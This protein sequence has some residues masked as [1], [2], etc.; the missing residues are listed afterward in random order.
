[1]V[2]VALVNNITLLV[3]LS[4]VHGIIMRRWRQESPAY[5]LIS[6][7]LFGGVTIIGMMIPLRLMP[8]VI[9]D[10]RSIIISVAGLF[11]GP[12]TALTTAALAA[13][14]R[15]WLGGTGALMGVCVIS[16]SALVG[17]L[18]YFLRRRD[19]RIMRPFWL[20]LFG[21]V[22]HVIM[23]ALTRTLPSAVSTQVFHQIAFP[24]IVVYPMASLLVCMLFLDQESRIR[25]ERALRAS[26][27][28]YRELVENVHSIILRWKPDGTISFMNSFGLQ[29]F[30]WSIDELVGRHVVGTIVPETEDTG[31]DLTR[32]MEDIISHPERHADNENE[33]MRRDGSR[34]W[35]RWLN[36]P[37]KDKHGNL[38]ELFSTGYDITDRKKAEAERNALE[39]RLRQS[40][41]LEAV[42]LL[43]GG[44]A[45]DFNNLLSP[46]LG[47]GEM[48][49]SDETLSD[50]QRTDIAE[51]VKAGKRARDLVKQLMAFGRKQTLEIKPLDLNGVVTG[52]AKLLRRTLREDIRLELSLASN[53]GSIRADQGQL[54]QVI[55]NLGVNAQDAMPNGGTLRIETSNVEV[56]NGQAPPPDTGTGQYVLLSLSDTGV[57]MDPET[58]ERIFEPFFTTK[59]PG[60]G[61]GLG[62]ASVY[63]IVKQH[64]GHI[65]VDSALGRGTTFRI[66]LPLADPPEQQE[67]DGPQEESFRGTETVLVAEDDPSVRELVCTMLRRM[68]YCVI[69][70]ATAIECMREVERF[71]GEI[72]LLLSDVVMPDMSGC[73]LAERLQKSRANMKVLYMS[74]YATNVIAQRGALDEGT[75]IIHKPFSQNDLGRRLLRMLDAS[76]G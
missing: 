70:A 57:G 2:F 48:L 49:E 58:Q 47:F 59:A 73:E 52:F 76:R 40:H 38:V 22:V 56:K 29:L 6:G 20:Y 33:N 74:G 10:G 36:H 4:L 25:A 16:E 1:M 45:H 24:V 5:K 11:G 61:V 28:S 26:K 46:I 12:I 23:L 35:I 62:L 41:K 72:H 3:S 30:G 53:L 37:I 27:E 60:K 63:G 17:M 13:G 68:G 21:L 42:G 44:V 8:G 32:L 69:S 50:E 9:F 15:I 19:P 31:R 71:K 75:E 39:E 34:V 14:Y 66:Y 7:L 54:E 18:F 67:D 55:M 65:V 43:A 64:E 51:I